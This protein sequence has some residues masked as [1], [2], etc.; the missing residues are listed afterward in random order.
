M[1]ERLALVGSRPDERADRL[2]SKHEL[3]RFR[4]ALRQYGSPDSAVRAIRPALLAALIS[5][6]V[7]ASQAEKTAKIAD[8]LLF[9]EA[10]RA[11]KQIV[12]LETPAEQLK[13][14]SDFPPYV[15]GRF[16]AASIRFEIRA[17][18]GRPRK[19]SPIA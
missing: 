16:L 2:L 10:Q 1:S 12:G 3:A 8:V 14:L 7:C 5:S 13:A 17:R 4:R 9:E 15:Q 6:P 11:G 19:R 18:R